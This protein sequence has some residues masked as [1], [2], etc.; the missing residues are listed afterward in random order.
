MGRPRLDPDL[1]QKIKTL[2]LA[3]KGQKEIAALLKV[4]RNRVYRFQ[5]SLGLHARRVLS[6]EIE[7]EILGLLKG[8]MGTSRIGRELGV[9]EH[10]AR[11]I[12]A[13]Y[14]FRRRPGEYG[15][16]YRIS[17]AKRKR[18]AEDILHRRDSAMQLARKHRISYRVMLKFV[19]KTLGCERLTPGNPAQPLESP[20]P[21]RWPKLFAAARETGGG[22]V[23]QIMLK[24]VDAVLKRSFDGQ[25]PFGPEYDA[26]FAAALLHCFQH[27]I[28]EFENQ[29]QPVLDNFSQEL[30]EAINI[31]RESKSA[32]FLN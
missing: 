1:K 17:R 3:G 12:V 22:S 4:H 15:Y 14:H 28:P 30:S 2:T 18:I 11:K 26:D 21:Q 31:L 9:G 5:R 27:L 20:L 6:L 23:E 29:P 32:Q 13:K 10:Q 8:G 16:R 25:F 24:L 19:K 7:Q